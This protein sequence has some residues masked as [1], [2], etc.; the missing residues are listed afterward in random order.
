MCN[1]SDSTVETKNQFASICITRPICA[2][3]RCEMEITVR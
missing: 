3:V 1:L 2:D